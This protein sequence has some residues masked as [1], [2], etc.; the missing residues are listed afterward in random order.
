MEKIKLFI[1]FILINFLSVKAQ[2]ELQ[3]FGALKIH[4]NGGIGFHSNLINNGIF[5]DNYGIAGF[6][7]ND[8][9]YITGAFMPI[10]NDI[11]VVLNNNLNLE[12]SVGVTNHSNFIS[13]DIKTPK[14]RLDITFD[15]T[16]SGFYSGETELSKING[17]SS[18]TNLKEFT[19]PVGDEV[20]I[21]P[22]R[23]ES[24]NINQIAKCAY[25]HEN[26]STP[27]TFN[28]SFNTENRTVFLLDVT[29]FEYW[30]LDS[31]QLS[32][33]NLEWDI[34]SHLD[35]MLTDLENLTVVGW[36][37]KNQT[38]ESL[39]NTFY[40]G[41]LV[42]GNITSDYFIPDDYEVITFGKSIS[43]DSQTADNL[44]LDNF[45][46][47]PNGDGSNDYFV[48]DGVVLSP[49]NL[50][51][52]FNRWGRVVYEKSNYNNEFEGTSNNSSTILTDRKLPDGVY[53]YIINL[54]DIQLRHQGFIY[55]NN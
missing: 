2:E 34:G 45:I 18:I 39:G 10:F 4:D 17:Y 37:K 32:T 24:I 47:S 12:V 16:E 38:W 36:S 8:D 3:N 23:I 14:D 6:Y 21:R 44:N 41:D 5:D 48:I 53:F 35:V 50:L 46:I 43:I 20:K 13:G 9:L 15:Y 27:S 33:V 11:E 49:N 55:I 19:F 25:F 31:E 42:S 7:S 52:I 54:Y 1:F 40:T 29:T 26:P 28:N 22:A 30:D 51:Q